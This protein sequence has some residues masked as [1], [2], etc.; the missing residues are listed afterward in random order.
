MT[1]QTIFDK[2]W[3]RHVVRDERDDAPALLYVDLHLLHEVTSAQAFTEL[4]ERGINVRRPDACLATVDHA[5]PTDVIERKTLG[6]FK[7]RQAA[8]QVETLI[9]NCREQGIT[10]HGLESQGQGIIHVIAPEQGRIHPGMTVVC[11]DS[12]TSTHGAFGALAFGIGTTQVAHVLAAQCLLMRKPRTMALRVDGKLQRGV[13]AKDLVLYLIS[14]IGASGGTGHVIEFQGPAIRA[15]SMEVRM[16]VCNMSIEAGARAGMIAP[17]E[18][19]FAYLREHA[20]KN[21]SWD[22]RIEQWN[23]LKSD[24][25]ARFD[26]V[27][28][29]D[30]NAI[31]PMVT[32]GTSPDHAIGV[33]DT[34]PEPGNDD[35]RAKALSYMSL[36]PGRKLAGQPVDV[37]FIGSCTNGRLSDL[38]AAAAVMRDKRVA[39][40][41]RVLV[42]PGSQRVKAEAQAEGLDK[43][44][45]NAG[46]EWREPGCSMCIAMNGDA[47]KS[48]QYCVSTSNRNFAGRQGTGGR[49]LLASPLTAAASAIAGCVADPRDY[50]QGVEA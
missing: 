38:R 17:D 25:G 5:I 22:K 47:L 23:A 7:D 12:H 10:L 48:G 24:P 6:A 8:S 36:E 1:P 29:F 18:T 15:L 40:H 35:S 46:C 13:S 33:H 37:V 26:T 31:Q 14:R 50:L 19:T 11:G 3:Q 4:R 41:T 43:V 32:Y 20:Q 21:E 44:F 28:T 27:H 39:K 34:I 9:A 42:V 16:T 30:A 45:I 2:V 49:T